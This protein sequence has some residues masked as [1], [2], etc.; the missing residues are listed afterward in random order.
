MRAMMLLVPLTL[1]M[2]AGPAVAD[3]EACTKQFQACTVSCV[4]NQA[5]DRQDTCILA[6]EKENTAC[7]SAA[8]KA[9]PAPPDAG[10]PVDRD[11]DQPTDRDA[12]QPTDRD[13]ERAGREPEPADAVPPPVPG[14]PQA[15]G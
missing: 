4:T 11:A 8:I 10:Q 1:A 3:E 6:C 15:G 14:E 7:F 9:R 12:G 2:M 5:P 13:G